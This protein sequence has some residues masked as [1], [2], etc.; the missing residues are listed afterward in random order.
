MVQVDISTTAQIH[1][2]LI[3]IV[4]SVQTTQTKR[5]KQWNEWRCSTCQISCKNNNWVWS[6]FHNPR[7]HKYCWP[8]F[9][10]TGTQT[11][12][13][14]TSHCGSHLSTTRNTNGVGRHLT[15]RAKTNGVCRHFK[16]RATQT[17]NNKNK[18]RKP[19]NKPMMLVGIS[20]VAQHYIVLVGMLQIR[21]K[22]RTNGVGRHFKPRERYK[23]QHTVWLI[24]Q[25]PDKQIHWFGRHFKA[26]T[27]KK[28]QMNYCYRYFSSSTHNNWCCSSF[29]PPRNN[30][31]TK[32]KRQQQRDDLSR[33]FKIRAKQTMFI[34]MLVSAQHNKNKRQHQD[35]RLWSAFHHAR[36]Q[37]NKHALCVYFVDMSTSAQ[38]PQRWLW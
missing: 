3:D 13:N 23:Q 22:T 30:T 12:R 31:T 37:N 8:T 17:H 9:Q 21:V 27:K 16:L 19:T 34:D 5:N 33:Q 28:R 38:Q 7:N 15:L 18:T 36:T 4:P 32:G 24:F 1:T 29:G 11:R 10:Y 26:H 35:D 20:T 2:A 6:V 14:C 25:K